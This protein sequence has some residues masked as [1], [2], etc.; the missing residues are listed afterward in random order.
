MF[1]ATF[2]NVGECDVAEFRT[3]SERDK[4]VNYQDE[5]SL[6]FG[7]NKET[8]AFQRKAIS[9]SE[10]KKLISMSLYKEEDLYGGKMTWY[11]P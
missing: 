7:C 2:K 4:W 11:I 3:E 10:A 8:A 5:F 1:Y 6:M 9:G